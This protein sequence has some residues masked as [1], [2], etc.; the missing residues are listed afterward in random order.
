MPLFCLEQFVTTITIFP[1][2]RKVLG[3][4]L[5]LRYHPDKN[6]GDQRSFN[7]IK[8]SICLIF[9][10]NQ[11]PLPISATFANVPW[12]KFV[13]DVQNILVPPFW[14]IDALVDQSK[15]MVFIL[16]DKNKDCALHCFPLVLACR[17]HLL[18]HTNLFSS[19][20]KY[21]WFCAC[22]YHKAC[23]ESAL[24]IFY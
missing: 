23:Y 22:S 14:H 11:H 18:L 7:F 17:L 5:G 20:E 21:W 6:H 19:S 13:S 9:F 16:Q 3:S 8:R 12:S 15:I 10:C 1:P 24:F 4:A 2:E